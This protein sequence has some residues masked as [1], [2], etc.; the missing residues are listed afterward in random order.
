L[1]IGISC[2]N[3]ALEIVIHTGRNEEIVMGARMVVTYRRPRDEVAFD[4][5]YFAVQA[6]RVKQLP[7]LRRYVVSRASAAG[8]DDAYLIAT[9][10]FDSVAAIQAACA[11][12][13]G[14]A[15]RQAGS[16]VEIV[17]PGAAFPAAMLAPA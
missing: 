11:S 17:E 2:R 1:N 10:D 4:R 3:Q 14:R 7:G 12:D 5:D 13:V 9:L 15:C 8:A 16:T 6:P